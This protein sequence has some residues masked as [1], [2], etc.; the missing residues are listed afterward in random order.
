MQS[1]VSGTPTSQMLFLRGRLHRL[2][3]QLPILID[4]LDDDHLQEAWKVLQPIYYN[5]YMLNAI[6]EAKHCLQPGESL[7]RDEA[8][9]L[10][11]VP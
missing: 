6:Q 10:L 2:A 9:R 1:Q 7:T 3:G 5:L 11:H 4:H 8:I